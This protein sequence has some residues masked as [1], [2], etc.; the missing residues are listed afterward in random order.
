MRIGQTKQPSTPPHPSKRSKTTRSPSRQ[1]STKTAAA[2]RTTTASPAAT[3]RTTATL[4][5]TTSPPTRETS[6]PTQQGK[7]TLNSN[8]FPNLKFSQ[9]GL[10]ALK[11]SEKNF[12]EF[13]EHVVAVGQIVEDLCYPNGIDEKK[14]TPRKMFLDPQFCAFIKLAWR[15]TDTAEN[16]TC[17]WGIRKRKFL[18]AGVGGVKILFQTKLNTNISLY[19]ESEQHMKQRYVKD[20]SW[21]KFV[22]RVTNYY[23]RSQGIC[24]VDGCVFESLDKLFGAIGIENDHDLENH[25]DVIG[26]LKKAFEFNCSSLGKTWGE[27]LAEY[28]K[29]LSKCSGHHQ[30]DASCEP[31]WTKLPDKNSKKYQLI[32]NDGLCVEIEDA[33]PIAPCQ[34]MDSADGRQVT[35]MTDMYLK[36]KSKEIESVEFADLMEK[37]DRITPFAFIDI[38]RLNEEKWDPLTA[39]QRRY[40]IRRA[41]T[42]AIKKMTRRCFFC[43][44]NA[45]AQPAKQS[46][47]FHLHHVLEKLKSFNP[48]EGPKKSLEKQRAELRKTIMLCC[49]CHVRIT[50]CELA[51]SELM[52]KFKDLGFEVNQKTGEITCSQEYDGLRIHSE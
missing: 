3:A 48:S 42:I 4:S 17:A 49:H 25:F 37:Y 41:E 30:N 2:T 5:A 24:I 16:S 45:L 6:P 14:K 10:Q 8:D 27:F 36:M 40:A 13:I 39:G 43:G 20:G 47:S 1:R 12:N 31:C 7:K 23:L 9:E 18:K 21:T 34:V 26:V 38:A 50:W 35:Q 32:A 22:R 33:N 28:A 29:T 11:Y 15:I 46:H 44:K 52:A 51:D 19:F